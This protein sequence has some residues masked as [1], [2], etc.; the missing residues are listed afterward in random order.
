GLFWLPYVPRAMRT[1]FNA[2]SIVIYGRSGE[3]YLVSE[4]GMEHV[5]TLERADL[6]RARFAKGGLNPRGRV[7]WLKEDRSPKQV[8]LV[9]PILAG[10]KDTCYSMLDIPVPVLGVKGMRALARDFAKWKIRL[11]EEEVRHN[12]NQIV[13]MQEVVGSGGA[14]FR[15]MFAAF[16]AEAAAVLSS[17]D[18][19]QAGLDMTVLGDRW[20]EFALVAARHV[21]NR[22]HAGDTYET[23]IDMLYELA[24]REEAAYRRLR[25]ITRELTAAH[26]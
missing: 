6:E 24:D 13:M 3:Q 5:Q 15:F 4:P 16:L 22:T 17:P 18:L 25:V 23:M 2:H 20:R 8:D 21:K 1:H 12:I 11:T 19:G 10:L 9:A 14:G 26:P 7:Y